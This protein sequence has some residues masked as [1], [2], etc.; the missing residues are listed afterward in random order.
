[1]NSSRNIFVFG[2]SMFSAMVI[3]NWILK[4]PESISTG[5]KPYFHYQ[6]KPFTLKIMLN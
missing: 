1:M 5:T 6:A 4:H 2:F 3:P